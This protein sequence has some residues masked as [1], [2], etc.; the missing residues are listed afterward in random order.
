MTGQP[1]FRCCNKCQ[2]LFSGPAA[3]GACPAGGQHDPGTSDDYT[4]TVMVTPTEP[5]WKQWWVCDRC[6]GIVNACCGTGACPAS[7][8]GGHDG[9]DSPFYTLT[10]GTDLATPGQQI[11]WHWCSK[12]QALFFYL[13]VKTTSGI[14]PAGGSHNSAPLLIS[15]GPPPNYYGTESI[16]LTIT[17]NVPPHLVVD[18]SHSTTG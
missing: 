3:A 18:N 14:C 6:Q 4:L 9:G 10:L 16:Y 12:C 15:P 8:G 1:G 13:D 17:A 5:G 2:G 11:G 7:G